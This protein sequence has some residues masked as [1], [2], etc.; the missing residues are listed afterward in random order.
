VLVSQEFNLLVDRNFVFL[1]VSQKT[2]IGELDTLVRQSF[3]Q[4]VLS[5]LVLKQ[6]I[7]ML[8]GV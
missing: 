7:E 8:D 4:N 2:L 3:C 5:E 6:N 1:D